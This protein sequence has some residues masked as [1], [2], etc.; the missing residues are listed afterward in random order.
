MRS[1]LCFKYRDTLDYCFLNATAVARDVEQNYHCICANPSLSE[2]IVRIKDRLDCV[3]TTNGGCL[4]SKDAET[5]LEL[6]L[7]LDQT[8][9]WI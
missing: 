4:N 7:G 3:L 8:Q 1:S 9:L 2:Y 6:Q 5:I